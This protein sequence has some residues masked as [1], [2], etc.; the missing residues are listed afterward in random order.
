MHLV[1]MRRWLLVA[2]VSLAAVEQSATGQ[3]L[4]PGQ[5]QPI[6]QIPS[7]QAQPG[8][9]ASSPKTSPQSEPPQ[10]TIRTTVPLVVVPVNVADSKGNPVD[11]L[12][13]DDFVVL[14]DGKPRKARVEASDS[15]I[16]PLS[17]V[18]AVQTS[19]ISQPALLK[20]R[21]VGSIVGESVAGANGE[22]AI[23]GYSDEVKVLHKFTNDSN[24]IT[25]TFEDLKPDASI[26][27][28]TEKMRL[29]LSGGRM[30]D[31]I[32]KAADLLEHRPFEKRP[33]SR[34]TVILVIGETKD[35]GSEA[36]LADV[37]NRTQKL[38]TTIYG[39]SYSG[40]VTAFTTKATEY[41]PFGRGFDPRLAILEMAR[42]GQKSA[43]GAL[44]EATGGQHFSFETKGKLE[45]DLFAMSKEIHSRYYVSFTATESDQPL[46]HQLQISIRDQ[47]GV[48]V[49]ARP[50]YWTGLEHTHE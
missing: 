17:V 30:I 21:Q 36:K 12:N 1:L 25:D 22:V 3:T 10:T 45:N 42:I 32:A 4:A 40:Y 35:R 6:V 46:F 47:P 8:Q 23:V 15:I 50:G 48:L 29:K 49:H 19:D 20:I 11:G 28:T 27:V 14:D 39:L 31:A 5:A 24:Q 43:M 41:E 26:G 2:L 7:G 37:I 33:L 18:I 34:R 13:E 9:P 44:V 16:A 38:A